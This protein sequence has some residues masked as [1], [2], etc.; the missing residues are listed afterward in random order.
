V[1]PGGGSRAIEGQCRFIRISP[2]HPTLGAITRTKEAQTEM[3]RISVKTSWYGVAL[4][5]ITIALVACDFGGGSGSGSSGGGAQSKPAAPAAPAKPAVF[6]MGGSYRV[7]LQYSAF[8]Y[9]D[10]CPASM[11]GTFQPFTVSYKASADGGNVTFKNLGQ[12]FDM[13]GT[14]QPDG[15]MN[16]AGSMPLGG[17]ITQSSTLL[18]KW[19]SQKLDLAATIKYDGFQTPQG[20]KGSCNVKSK[21]TGP[22]STA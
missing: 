13:I 22:V 3:S 18:G 16:L 7:D 6:N 4:A 10:D 1:A 15:S 19:S 2:G 9:G 21:A 14:A 20:A 11:K 17:G 8:E 5:A 12:G